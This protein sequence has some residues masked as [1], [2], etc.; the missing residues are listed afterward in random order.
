MLLR[1]IAKS[2]VYLWDWVTDRGHLNAAISA[3]CQTLVVLLVSGFGFLKQFGAISNYH[4]FL[5]LNMMGSVRRDTS[6]QLCFI[7]Q[8]LSLVWLFVIPWTAA[9]Q[10]PLSSPISQSLLK[11][12]CIELVM[13]SNHL[14]LC[15][16]LLLLPLI[17]S[18]IKV[19]SSEPALLMRWPQ[20][21]SFS[22]RIS[23]SNE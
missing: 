9:H 17:F 15:H 22:F 8:S 21:W 11:S 3:W 12:M 2:W 6:E 14:I 1:Q 19:F 13:L 5:F 10:S 18:R 16:P 4:T 7:V 23:L 20:Y